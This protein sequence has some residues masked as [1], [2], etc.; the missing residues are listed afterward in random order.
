MGR[1]DGVCE[2]CGGKA[3][4]GATVCRPCY[5]GNNMHPPCPTCG[6]P[7]SN[8]RCKQC[9]DCWMA[10]RSPRPH[11]SECGV[12]LASGTRKTTQRC[13]ACHSKGAT[14]MCVDCGARLPKGSHDRKRCWPCHL[15]LRQAAEI[16]VCT[17]PGCGRAHRAKGLCMLHYLAER[18]RINGVTA[19]R[20]RARVGQ[21]PCQLCG[22][23]E[24]TSHVHRIVAQGP[25]TLGNMVALCA[26][27]HE[28]VHRGK[29]P[30]PPAWQPV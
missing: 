7:L 13:W 16:Q 4:T 2:R 29:R 12:R 23:D 14:D 22:F 30:C 1:W 3:R 27:C 18:R 21:S 20:Y 19:D 9:R 26:T 25:Y 6:K 28:L 17:R 15:R 8:R 24:I 11:C 10:E 5:E